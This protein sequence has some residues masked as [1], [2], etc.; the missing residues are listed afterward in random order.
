M[1][2]VRSQAH[3]VSFLLFYLKDLRWNPNAYW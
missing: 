3:Y 2:S 1:D